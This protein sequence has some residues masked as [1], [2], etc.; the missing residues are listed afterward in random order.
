MQLRE[1]TIDD[2]DTLEWWDMQAHIVDSVPGTYKWERE[3]KRKPDWRRQWIAEQN[4]ESIAFVQVIDPSIDPSR[5][6]GNTAHGRQRA[7]E[8]WIGEAYNLHRGYGSTIMNMV[9]EQVFEDPV[10]NELLVDPLSANKKAHRFY[11]R[12][13]FKF[14]EAKKLGG[15]TCYVMKLKR[16]AYE[17][18]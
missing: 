2:L 5:Y 8:I 9:I 12:L 1:T 7:I 3:L 4:G 6:W 16:Q 18:P 10:V 14:S 13:G 17:N 15:D 11:T